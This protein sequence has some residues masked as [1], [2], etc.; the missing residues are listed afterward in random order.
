MS[1]ASVTARDVGLFLNAREDFE[2]YISESDN[3]SLDELENQLNNVADQGEKVYRE[4]E[5]YGYSEFKQSLTDDLLLKRKGEDIS[6]FTSAFRRATEY[7]Q[8]PSKHVYPEIS[9][10]KLSDSEF[11]EFKHMYMQTIDEMV[12][13]HLQD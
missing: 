7:L 1:P 10:S 9:E 5:D 6:K 13:N 8:N 3:L 12:D 4:V 11:I 2:N